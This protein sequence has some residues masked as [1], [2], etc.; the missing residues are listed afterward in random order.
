M[1]LRMRAPVDG[2]ECVVPDLVPNV[3]PDV[4]LDVVPE[5]FPDMVLDVVRH[6]V[7]TKMRFVSERWP[8]QSIRRCMAP[9]KSDRYPS[10]SYQTVYVT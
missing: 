7:T 1:D 8:G 6:C 10:L 5:V 3:V 9:V 2:L 4:V